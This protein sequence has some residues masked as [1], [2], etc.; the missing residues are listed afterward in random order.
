[1]L[2][3]FIIF[4]SSFSKVGAHVCRLDF[5]LDTFRAGSSGK[6]RLA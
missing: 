2:F 1:L 6:Q 4:S 3:A 5:L